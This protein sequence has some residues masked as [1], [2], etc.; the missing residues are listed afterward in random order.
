[1]SVQIINTS[2]SHANNSTG[3]LIDTCSSWSALAAVCLKSEI[4]EI[5]EIHSPTMKSTSI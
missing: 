3:T 5:Q 1:M 2:I 4:Q